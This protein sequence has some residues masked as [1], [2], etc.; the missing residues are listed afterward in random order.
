MEMEFEQSAFKNIGLSLLVWF[1]Y[2]KLTVQ[3]EY[4]NNRSAKTKQETNVLFFT[5][6]KQSYV[7]T[8]N[9]QAYNYIL[10]P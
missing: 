10:L 8:G 3:F 2:L 4:K 9:E 7:K 6:S 1:N 5:S